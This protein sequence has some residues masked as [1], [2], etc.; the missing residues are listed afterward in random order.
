[1]FMLGARS[2]CD[3][4]Q[5]YLTHDYYKQNHQGLSTHLMALEPELVSDNGQMVRRDRLGGSPMMI[6]MWPDWPLCF[7]HTGILKHAQKPRQRQ[8]TWAPV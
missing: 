4:L 1:M 8:G 3:V 2:R 6:E 5:Q 7:N